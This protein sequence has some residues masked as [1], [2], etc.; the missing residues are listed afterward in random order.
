MT[1]AGVGVGSGS[2]AALLLLALALACRPPAPGVSPVD[3]SLFPDGSPF[4]GIGIVPDIE[5]IPTA[6]DIRDG[7]DPALGAAIGVFASN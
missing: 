4:H 1:P 3:S 5:I 2:E 7:T 6:A